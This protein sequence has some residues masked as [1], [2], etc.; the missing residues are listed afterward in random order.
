MGF[1]ADP[2]SVFGT[3]RFVTFVQIQKL[4]VG[5]VLALFISVTDLF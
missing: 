4:V 1:M 5:S 3:V 2:F